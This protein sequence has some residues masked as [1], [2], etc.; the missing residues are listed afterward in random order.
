LQSAALSVTAKKGIGMEG[1]RF[2]ALVARVLSDL[3]AEF[4]NKL[5]NI[6]VVVCEHPT[7]RQ[8]ARLKRGW[9]LLGLYEGVPHTERT[10]SYNMVLPDRITLF[11]Q[12][13]EAN[14]HCEEEIA[15]EVRRVVCHE[16][17][18]HFGIDDESL[19]RI[20]SEKLG[21]KWTRR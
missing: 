17:A 10:Q 1:E 6:D 14:C 12:P 18:H 19:W 11:Q 7:P 4:R 16:I 5:E 9:T 13:I 21:E 20:E 15:E 3:P 8:L 2:R